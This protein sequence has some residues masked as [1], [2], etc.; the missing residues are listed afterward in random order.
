MPSIYLANAQSLVPKLNE[1]CVI[2]CVIRPSIIIICETWLTEYVTDNQV[3]L[4][5]Y[6]S[7]FRRDRCDGRQGGGVAIFVHD[8]TF[9]KRHDPI[10]SPDFPAENLW[11]TLPSVKLLIIALYIPPNLKTQAL[12]YIN[13]ELIEHIEDTLDRFPHLKVIISGDLNNFSTKEI[14]DTFNLVQVISTPT[15]GD[16][17]L[18]KVLI[19]ESLVTAYKN[20][21]VGPNLGNSDHRSVLIRPTAC[22]K[23]PMTYKVKNVYDFRL[24]HLDNFRLYL[25]T[26]PWHTFFSSYRSVEEK[27]EQFYKVIQEALTIIPRTQ[28]VMT[29]KDKPWITP[30]IKL[31]INK[32]YQAFRKKDYCMYN[33]YKDKVKHLIEETKNNWLK[34]TKTSTNGLWKI[35][36]D[37]INLPKNTALSSLTQSFSSSIDAA[38]AINKELC[39]NFSDAPDWDSLLQ[40]L[41]ATNLEDW[42]FR[43][44]EH[45][46][47][48][49]LKGLQLNKSSGND[50]LFPRLF[51][52][53][54][55][56]LAGPVC[57][58]ISL[59]VRESLVPTRWKAAD[60]TPVPKKKTP[61]SKTSV[62]SPF[63]LQ[64]SKSWRNVSSLH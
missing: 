38:E 60:V 27:C 31:L 42:N 14:E 50:D 9:S 30:L 45:E 53:A 52:E 17:L 28:V 34:S 10:N 7:L 23:A 54:H 62:Q 47:A 43:I 46:I 55:I 3:S 63:S 33:H 64:F 59:S 16:A 58:L 1:L 21:V 41:S 11:I 44:S 5:N 37:A 29:Q 61:L 40:S 15:R 39:K 35:C 20:V 12:E 18:D 26:Y 32:R 19:D 57:H 8:S 56:E 22:S 4:P 51:S 13:D 24:S 2:T 48:S 6:S 25:R 49:L 36:K